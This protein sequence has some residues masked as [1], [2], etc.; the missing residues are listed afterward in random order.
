MSSKYVNFPAYLDNPPQ[1]LFLEF[2]DLLPFFIGFSFG[3]IMEHLGRG[4]IPSPLMFGMI[5]GGIGTNYYIKY[6]RNS[7]TGILLHMGYCY[8]LGP[9]NKVF[10]MG[11]TKVLNN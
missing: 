6:K 11:F 2:D 1:L 5:L 8:G 4:I 3:V 10:K 7:L 9:L